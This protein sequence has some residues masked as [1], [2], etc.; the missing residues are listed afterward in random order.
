VPKSAVGYQLWNR[1]IGVRNPER[2]GQ[3]SER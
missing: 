3:A 2:I 1:L